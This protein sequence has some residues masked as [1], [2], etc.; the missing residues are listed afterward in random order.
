ME[1]EK[2]LQAINDALL[3]TLAACGDVNRN[4]MCNP[5]PYQSEVHAEVY[6]WAKRLSDYLLPQTR[7]YYEIWL[8]EEKV[9]GTPEVEQEPI[10]GPL[11][12]PRK[13]K[14]GIAVPPSNDVDVFSQDLGFIAIME[15]GKLVGFNVAIG[16]GMGMTHGDRT[17]YPQLAKVIGFCKPEQVID[18]AEK[19]LL[20]SVIMAIAPYVNMPALNIRLIGLVWM[21]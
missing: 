9:A 17:T 10:Y 1:H 5:N 21:Q 15:N 18:V 6:E 4:V 16:G 8:D 19:S 11:Y 12:L 13:F 20:F 7:A 3:T 14:I 2:T